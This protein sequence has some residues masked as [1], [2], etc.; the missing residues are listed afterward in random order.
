[1]EV[2]IA[3][4]DGMV[5]ALLRRTL[6][7]WGHD[8]VVCCDGLEAWNALQ[9]PDAPRLAVLDWLM[10]ELEGPEICRR[11]RSQKTD[12]YTHVLLLSVRA[13]RGD[14]LEAIRS[15][16]DDYM[17][18]PVDLSELEA[19][20][21]TA[22]RQLRVQEELLTARRM[23]F[24]ERKLSLEMRDV[25]ILALAK[26]A[27][28]RDPETG[29][30]LER[31]RT[32][33]RLLAQEL[34]DVPRFRDQIDEDFI[35]LI[36]RTSPLHDIGKVAIPDHVLLKPGQLDEDEFEIMKT[37]A[38]EGAATLDAAL[39]Q[40]PGAEYLH[41][42]R[43]IAAFHH[44]RFDGTGYATGLAGE[45]IP[46]CARIFAVADVYDALRS[47]RVYKQA[48]THGIAKSIILDG[49][50]TQFDPDV[51]EAMALHEQAFKMIAVGDEAATPAGDRGAA[52]E[53]LSPLRD[54]PA[55]SS[56]AFI[57]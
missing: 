51:V 25:V 18:K 36:Y 11:L 22:V 43:D 47:K 8:V 29:L 37:H 57:S 49:K 39:Q 14:I 40:Y 28:S 3:D 38:A 30:H 9:G 19:R 6:R 46:L 35:E 13:E 52:E 26:L 17:T 12:A 23:F 16:A 31:V 20:I 7:K 55:R 32:Y 2:L 50:G 1:M 48:F 45:D 4:D 53:G 5:R 42:A 44:E 24:D 34:A 33:S 15:G 27:E 21:A 41:M 56:P 10:P 54:D